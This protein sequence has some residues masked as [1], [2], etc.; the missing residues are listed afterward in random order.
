[1]VLITHHMP[2]VEAICNRVA[3]LDEGTVVEEGE[4]SAVFSSP[5]MCIRDSHICVE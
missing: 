4:V 5:K 3:I 1:M 2:V